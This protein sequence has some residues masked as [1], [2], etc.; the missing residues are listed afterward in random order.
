MDVHAAHRR[1]A[2]RSKQQRITGQK[3][4]YH[5]PGFAK[6]N[7]KQNGV[8]PRPVL[9]TKILQVLVDVEDKVDND[10]DKFH[11]GFRKAWIMQ[12]GGKGAILTQK[13]P[14]RQPLK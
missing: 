9:G 12:N 2:A 6:H 7:Q 13:P 8:N 14:L 5:Q 11:K 3:R 4:R 1:Q 10:A